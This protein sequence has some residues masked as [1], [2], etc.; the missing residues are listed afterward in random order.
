MEEGREEG[1]SRRER[2]WNDEE[3]EKIPK[4][5]LLKWL[6]Q[7]ANNSFLQQHSTD[8]KSLLIKAFNTLFARNDYWRG[9]QDEQE[10][11]RY[12]NTECPS[13]TTLVLRYLSKNIRAFLQELIEKLPEVLRSPSS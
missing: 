10:L 1:N 6:Q 13:L 3:L 7:N 8:N 11:F 5:E 4:K 12:H 2:P 9:E